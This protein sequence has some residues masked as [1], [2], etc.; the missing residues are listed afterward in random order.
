M[1]KKMMSLALA[2]VMCLSLCV[3]ALT[4][5]PAASAFFELDREF[6]DLATY[7]TALP[8]MRKPAR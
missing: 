1:K 3:P 8:L 6:T 5:E 7:Q 2:V 4:S